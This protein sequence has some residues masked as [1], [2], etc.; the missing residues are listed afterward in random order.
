MVLGFLSRVE[1]DMGSLLILVQRV[2]RLSMYRG[3]LMR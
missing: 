1:R 3:Q 2:V